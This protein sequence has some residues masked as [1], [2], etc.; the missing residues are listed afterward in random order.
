[1][2][3][4]RIMPAMADLLFEDMLNPNFPFLLGHISSCAL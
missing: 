1:M 3:G 2:G 4:E